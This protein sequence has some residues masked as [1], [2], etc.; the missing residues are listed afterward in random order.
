MTGR[1]PRMEVEK[2]PVSAD[3]SLQSRISVEDGDL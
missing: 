2:D 3:D 1:V